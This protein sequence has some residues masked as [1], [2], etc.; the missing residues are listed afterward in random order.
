[1]FIQKQVS[2]QCFQSSNLTFVLVGF[3]VETSSKFRCPEIISRSPKV[4]SVAR[5]VFLYQLGRRD[6]VK[7]TLLPYIIYPVS[8]KVV[9]SY[10]SV[11]H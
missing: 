6:G 8:G 5:W 7:R 1:M 9:Y 3:V 4:V 10:Q 2:L 11:H